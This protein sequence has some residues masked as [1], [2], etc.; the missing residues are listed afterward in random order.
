M[1]S[2]TGKRRA[3]RGDF[4]AVVGLA[5]GHAERIAAIGEEGWIALAE[6]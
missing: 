5:L 1:S 6:V 2:T 3:V 4:N